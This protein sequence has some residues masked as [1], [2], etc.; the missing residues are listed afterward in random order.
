MHV[1]TTVIRKHNHLSCIEKGIFFSLTIFCFSFSL[2]LSPYN[3]T[4][5]FLLL[6]SLFDKHF[7]VCALCVFPIV[8]VLN[9]AI[10]ICSDSVSVEHW[11]GQ[12]VIAG[13]V[14]V[15]CYVLCAVQCMVRCSKALGYWPGHPPICSRAQSFRNGRKTGNARMKEP[16]FRL[17]SMMHSSV[18][19]STG[20]SSPHMCVCVRL[21]LGRAVERNAMHN[22]HGARAEQCKSIL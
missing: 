12:L 6:G 21:R 16:V 11:T 4:R 19:N 15:L 9:L 5:Q 18:M 7:R 22:M 1:S 8:I 2:T 10:L 17:T 20:F 14:C 3:C 13:G